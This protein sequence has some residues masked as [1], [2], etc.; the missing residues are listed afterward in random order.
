MSHWSGFGLNIAKRCCNSKIS[1]FTPSNLINM[2]R[3]SFILIFALIVTNSFC[4]IY[5]FRGP[6]RDG[7]FKET[8]L[9]DEWPA[10][11]PEQILEIE[12]IGKGWS[13]PVVTDDA[14]YITGMID[15]QDHLSAVDF[16]GNI[17]WQVSY[18]E[19]WANSFPDTRSSPT[20]EDDRIYVLSGQGV[21]SCINSENGEMIW[22]VD[23]DGIY[24][25]EWHSWGVAESILIVDDKVICT[26]G[27]S[28][29]SVI[30]LDKTTGELVWQTEGFGDQRSYVSPTLFE[31]MGTT[32]IL[33]AT[34]RN[35]LAIIPE[36]G[37]IKWK[38]NYFN[39]DKWTYQPGLIWTN[40][41]I[42]DKDRIWISK[43][44]DWPG[45]ML[46]VDSSGNGVSKAYVDHTFDNHHHGGI[47]IDGFLYG[48]NW[49]N[50]RLGKWVCMNWDTGEI[51]WIEPWENKGSI[52][53]ADGKLFLYEE[54]GGN[55]ALVNPDPKG[56]DLVSSFKIT[57]GSGPH[58]AHP[59]IAHGNLYLRHGD[60][61]MVYEIK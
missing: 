11:G 35:L 37:E 25:A 33:A 59:Y 10:E 58:W 53:S 13:S 30:A 22:T 16:D 24:E 9:L 40:T 17:I 6:D 50:N 55:V 41:P 14:I 8:G 20:I 23:V 52:I 48:S 3:L 60:V 15:K 5:Q 18:G 46:K 4:Q 7:F 2:K 45:V 36:T 54:K 21:L 26:P 56:F 12:G 28:K 34:A 61:L 39:E 31:F 57:K 42:H 38:F 47:L 27:G 49:Q 32:H 43:G 19:S 29:T 51:N 1:I 44:Y